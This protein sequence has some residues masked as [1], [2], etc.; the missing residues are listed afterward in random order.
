MLG[1][2]EIMEC[3]DP[4]LVGPAIESN[5][6]SSR[7]AVWANNI[8]CVAHIPGILGRESTFYI[9]KVKSESTNS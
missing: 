9:R 7:D 1:N 8:E 4:C 5:R 6:L 3:L 2:P